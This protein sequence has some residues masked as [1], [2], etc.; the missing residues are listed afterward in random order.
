MNNPFLTRTSKK[1]K[2]KGYQGR[3]AESKV[4]KRIGGVLQPGSGALLSAKGDMVV[5]T[6]LVSLLVEN[7]STTS[8]SFAVKRDHLFKIHQEALEVGKIPALTFQFVD[9]N[10]ISEKRE[11]WVCVPEWVLQALINKEDL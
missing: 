11:R 10:G 2:D 1:D 6:E 7:K 9:N 4:S 3:K 5:N 8:T